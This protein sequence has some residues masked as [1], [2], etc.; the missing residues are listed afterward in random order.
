MGKQLWMFYTGNAFGATGIG[1][2]TL[3]KSALRP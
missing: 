2:A 1:L 3:D